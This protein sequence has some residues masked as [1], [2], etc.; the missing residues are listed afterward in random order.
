MNRLNKGD[1]IERGEKYYY[2]GILGNFSLMGTLRP[3]GGVDITCQYYFLLIIIFVFGPYQKEH[4]L[5]YKKSNLHI[6]IIGSLYNG[7]KL[8]FIKSERKI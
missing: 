6:Q 5:V 3:L 2:S 1:E 8:R 7:Y 4:Y